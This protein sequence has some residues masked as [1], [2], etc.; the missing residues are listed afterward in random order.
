MLRK[1]PSLSTFTLPT[2][3]SIRAPSKALIETLSELVSRLPRENYDLLL[4]VVELIR[5]TAAHSDVTKMPLSNLLLIF[6]PSLGMMPGL[7]RTLCDSTHLWE[8][9]AFL[10][11]IHNE[12][13][14]DEYDRDSMG[15]DSSSDLEYEE[16]SVVFNTDKA[17]GKGREVHIEDT[18]PEDQEDKGPEDTEPPSDEDVVL[19]P[20]GVKPFIP[21]DK[22]STSTSPSP[23]RSITPVC[24]MSMSSSSLLFPSSPGLS[25]QQSEMSLTPLDDKAS[26]SS[27]NT[28]STSPSQV[29]VRMAAGTADYDKE[30]PAF[31]R[32]PL[33]VQTENISQSPM[34]NGEALLTQ[35]VRTYG[36]SEPQLEQSQKSRFATLP[37][38]S[39]MA[40]KSAPSVIFPSYGTAP[41]T[42]TFSRRHGLTLSQGKSAKRS[43]DENAS[44]PTP[45]TPS[46]RVGRRP[47]MNLL[48]NPKRS[49]SP[50]S[51][52]RTLT[53]SGPISP[54]LQ[55]RESTPSPKTIRESLPP[56]L[57]LTTVDTDLSSD[58]GWDEVFGENRSQE[59]ISP[60]PRATTLSQPSSQMSPWGMLIPPSPLRRPSTEYL[61]S[62]DGFF[63]PNG[64]PTL[65]PSAV[66]VLESGNPI[67]EAARPKASSTGSASPVESNA[68]VYREDI[69]SS[70][71]DSPPLSSPK[72]PFS[73]PPHV[74]FQLSGS[75]DD[76][77]ASV[78]LLAAGKPDAFDS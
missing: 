29:S 59:V 27:K 65:L 34:L 23:S 15:S 17:K 71:D 78:V 11:D 56:V 30:L 35:L 55:E 24:Q 53:I 60:Q 75:E 66:A 26:V 40:S 5:A 70:G 61:L 63:G 49:A 28:L 64:P 12:R 41:S 36:G 6:C 48:F 1:P 31:P 10:R 33:A 51:H 7:L 25:S 20:R 67:I 68:G 19:V 57:S 72:E 13:I 52:I 54:S 62:S 18:Q 32:P 8:Q 42:P 58:L 38:P 2:S 73:P 14:A 77:W 3:A 16:E 44:P 45:V 39:A 9:A 37:T 46:K 50:I 69:S 43:D 4:T 76:D 22:K 74:G 21:S 47:S